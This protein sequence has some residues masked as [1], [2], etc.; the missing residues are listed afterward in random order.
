MM[1]EIDTRA[2]V[3]RPGDGQAVDAPV[4]RLTFKARAEETGGAATVFESC[5]PP[6][7]GPPLH[8][9]VGDDELMYVLAGRLRIRLGEE[10]Q[11]APAGSLV[12]IPKGVTHT[13]QNA[14][15]EDARFLAMFA[16]AAPG[17]E[18]F[19][20]RSADLADETRLQEGFGNFAEDAGMKVLGPPLGQSELA[21]R[22]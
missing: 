14:A 5:A 13:W 2:F 22:T 16:P 9:H 4:G 15:D 19:F 11:E 21:S 10:I 3:R 8:V 6:G 18:R 17:M 12:F 1:V 20:E 7:Q